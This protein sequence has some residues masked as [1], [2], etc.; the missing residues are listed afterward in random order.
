M[1]LAVTNIESANAMRVAWTTTP[2]DYNITAS[3]PA[4]LSVPG[5]ANPSEG[6][7][8]RR[9]V[10]GSTGNLAV[11]CL[12]GTTQVIPVDFAG[13]VIDLQ[14]IALVGASSTCTNVKVYW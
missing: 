5:L 1:T 8:C 7:P 11:T 9:L 14:A 2:A 4:K 10:P 6:R 13:Q 3:D 12:D